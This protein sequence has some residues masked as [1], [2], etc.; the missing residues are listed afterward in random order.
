MHGEERMNVTTP[1]IPDPPLPFTGGRIPASEDER[2]LVER[3]VLQQYIVAP[4]LSF[5]ALLV[6]FNLGWPR[7][8]ALGVIGFGL[9]A[10]LFGFFAVSERRLMFIRGAL[11]TPRDYRYF[12]YEGVAAV[13]YGLAFMVGALCL[14]APAALFFN[15]I[16]LERMR[17]AV[18]ARP[19]FALVPVGALLLF[20]GLGF[21]IGFS[22]RAASVGDRLWIE[23]MHLPTRLTGLILIAW[24]TTLLAVGLI[25][26][27]WPELFHQWFQSISGNPW[28]FK[29]G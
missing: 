22:R 23:L 19:S 29:W 15:G 3:R 17:D 4:A 5:V 27:L 21:L 13:P 7:L 14:I 28:P 16:S 25:E 26:W 11:G 1:G 8:A 24:A 20:H 6:G 10:L 2:R 9:T 12:I 18:L